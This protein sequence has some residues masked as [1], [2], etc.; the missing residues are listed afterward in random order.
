MKCSFCCRLLLIFLLQIAKDTSGTEFNLGLHLNPTISIPLLGKGS[1]YDK[2]II[3]TPMK[4]SYNVG[5][6]INITNNK[7]GFETGIEIVQKKVQLQSKIR[8]SSGSNSFRL[9]S[10][11]TS[12]EFPFLGA[13]NV[14]NHDRN[15][16][17]YKLYLV[18]GLSYEIYSAD[19]FAMG[20]LTTNAASYQLTEQSFD[21]PKVYDTHQ[22]ANVIFGFK[23]N[24][25]IRK[26]GLI[27]YG[28][29]YHIPTE[30]NS[31]YVIES[32]VFDYGTRQVYTY[33]G[34]FRPR[35][36]YL[37][38]K[39]CYYMLNYNSRFERIRYKQEPF[40]H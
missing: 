3:L 7:V 22:W 40:Y 18:G 2:E 1:V 30:V 12:F 29:T 37:N 21:I 27:D 33:H 16:I 13:V 34:D 9:V 32:K 19:G 35:L 23:I 39:L 10:N 28:I 8:T 4:M 25:I 26:L 11:S 17:V 6:N 20:F 5:A 14:H 15:D 24:T 38:I 31:P 36:S